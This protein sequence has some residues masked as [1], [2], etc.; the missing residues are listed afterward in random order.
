[1]CQRPQHIALNK[2]KASETAEYQRAQ[3]ANAQEV[4]IQALHQASNSQGGPKSLDC[5]SGYNPRGGRQTLAYQVV[6][7]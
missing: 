2:C 1:M 6:C 4:S 5:R 7:Y 3:L